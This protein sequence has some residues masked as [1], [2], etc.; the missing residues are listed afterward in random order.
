MSE[1]A[2]VAPL[3][4][5]AVDLRRASGAVADAASDE[6]AHAARLAGEAGFDAVVVLD[7]GMGD[8]AIR[9]MIARTPA[10]LLGSD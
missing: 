9:T 6:A 4:V 2:R 5:G 1:D 10:E 7:Y 8:D 3:L